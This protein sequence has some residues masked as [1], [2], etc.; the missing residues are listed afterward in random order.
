MT[1]R[2]PHLLVA[3]LLPLAPGCGDAWSTTLEITD[4]AGAPVPFP[5]VLAGGQTLEGD[6]KGR[7][8]LRGLRSPVLAQVVAD[9]FLAEPVPVGPDWQGQQV[10]VRLWSDEGGARFAMHSG[11]DVMLGR[12]FLEPTSGEPLVVTDDGGASARAVVSDLAPAFGLATLSTVNLETVVGDLSDGLAY[13]GKRYLLQSPPEALDALDAL[14]VDLVGLANNHSRDWLDEGIASTLAW[15]DLAGLPNAGA[16][17]DQVTAAQWPLFEV[18]QARIAMLAWTTLGGESVN[19]YLPTDEEQAPDDAS[20]S[21]SPW[22]WEARTWGYPELGVPQ[23]DRRAGSAWF[24]FSD[25][26]PSLDADQVADLWASLVGVYPE[27]QDLLARRGHG[28]ANGW[29]EETSPAQVAEAA[30]LADVVV[31]Q[32]HSGMEYAPAPSQALVD[33]AHQAV[34]AGADLVVAH[35]PH[36]LQGAEWYRGVPILWSM[37]N[38]VFDQ[39]RFI[40]FPSAFLRTVWEADGSLL[41]A[42]LLPLYMDGYRPVPLV[43]QAGRSVLMQAWDRSFIDGQATRL[44]D[45]R[46]LVVYPTARDPQASRGGMVREWGTARLLPEEPAA[47][48]EV[49]QLPPAGW[50]SLPPTGLVRRGLL[51]APPPDLEVGR[52]LIGVSHFEDQDVD[53]VEDDVPG[54]RIEEPDAALTWRDAATGRTSLQLVRGPDNTVATFVRTVGQIWMPEHRYYADEAGEV[55]IDGDARYSVHVVGYVQ[56]EED[57]LRVRLDLYE[58]GDPDPTEDPVN[59]LLRAVELEVPLRAGQWSEAL[60]DL[61]AD[62]FDPVDGVRPNAALVYLLL[63]PPAR[64][65]T[66]ARIDSVEVVEWRPAALEPDGF[67][68]VDLVR[69][70]GPRLLR[71]ERLPW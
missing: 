53:G 34:D 42:R 32:I 43:G 4:Q 57:R 48:E 49:V 26:E 19:D 61:P 23:A 25:L 60:V 11:G 62:A 51:D 70:D 50:A 68:Q 56:G 67:G 14:G 18:G 35:H 47:V 16:G 66:I 29:D 27:L 59:D 9:G 37:G 45:G 31:V 12:R 54:W 13:P 40:T 46:E 7:V 17:L 55:P 28:G 64:R 39:D 21:L 3:A 36:V 69:A 24:L 10:R 2:L 30:T 15:V 6:A 65:T 38:L 58:A 71:F 33:A 44:E 52:A 20:T 22:K 8:H 1:G 5:Q 63:E 41:E